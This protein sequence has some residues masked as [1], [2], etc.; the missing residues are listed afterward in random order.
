MSSRRIIPATIGILHSYDDQRVLMLERHGAGDIHDGFYVWPC[1]KQKCDESSVDCV[2]R[3]FDEETGL[4]FLHPKLRAIVM[5][6]NE[7]RINP[8]G[9]LFEDDYLCS[10]YDSREHVGQLRAE[11]DNLRPIWIFKSPLP[12]T[13]MHECDR[14]LFDLL[15][16]PGVYDVLVK[17][18]GNRLSRFD[19][20]KVD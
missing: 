18:E 20:R 7:G 3:E 2:V 4:G 16:N 8:N 17:Y 11:S 1:V 6:S 15:K 14:L 19:S 13:R 5:F 9:N 12:K 10:V